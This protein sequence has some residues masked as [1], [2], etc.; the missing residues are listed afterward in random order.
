MI[1]ESEDKKSNINIDFVEDELEHIPS[2]CASVS[3]KN[4]DFC[5]R[6]DMV[7]FE[8]DV[9]KDFICE[10]ERLDMNREG[11]ATLESMSP[12]DLFLSI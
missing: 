4:N 6:N 12:E 2:I 7:W 9:L 5:G 1:I 8:L 11:I 3:V 10:L